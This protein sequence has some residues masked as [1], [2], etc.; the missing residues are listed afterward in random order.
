M[1][2]PL[3]KTFKQACFK[4]KDAPLTIEEVDLKLPSSGE[5]LVKV[6]ACGVCHSDTFAQKNFM[7]GG[8]YVPRICLACLV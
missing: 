7:G 4:E 8:L 5:V 1:S 2:S 3:P 6:E